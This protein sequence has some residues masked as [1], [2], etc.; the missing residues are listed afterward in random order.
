M[1]WPCKVFLLNIL[2][3]CIKCV[4][5]SF[6]ILYV[7]ISKRW[8]LYIFTTIWYVMKVAQKKYIKNLVSS[9]N[10]DYLLHLEATKCDFLDIIHTFCKYDNWKVFNTNYVHYPASR[11]PAIAGQTTGGAADTGR[12]E[13][14]FAAA[15]DPAATA[16]CEKCRSKFNDIKPFETFHQLSKFINSRLPPR[17]WTLC[18]VRFCS[19]STR[20]CCHSVSPM[21]P[22]KSDSSAVCTRHHWSTVR[23]VIMCRPSW[24]GENSLLQLCNRKY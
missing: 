3:I 18:T 10:K 19:V 16:F 20:C 4:E 8:M 2:K 9:N 22:A 13:A 6:V 15:E 5:L 12:T 7:K 21:R 24:A 17:T 11:G 1:S 14:S 23:T